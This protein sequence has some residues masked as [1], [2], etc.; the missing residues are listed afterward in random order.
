MA[1]ARLY[2]EA[3]PVWILDEPFTALDREGVAQ[4]E[5]HLARHCDQGGGVVLTTHHALTRTAARYR[6]LELGRQAA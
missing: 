1:L 5:D 4:L 2:L 6:P 3:P